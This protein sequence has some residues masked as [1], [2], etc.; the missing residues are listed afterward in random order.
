MNRSY[1]GLLVE[2]GIW[3]QM[4]NFSTNSLA[5]I[6]S[7]ESYDDSDYVRDYES[8]INILNREHC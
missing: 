5:F 2:N 7:S 8:F 1:Y 4:K 3:R 6:V